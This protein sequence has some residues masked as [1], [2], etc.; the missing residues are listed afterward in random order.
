MVK[1]TE[2][3]VAQTSQGSSTGWGKAKQIAVPS[4]AKL[5]FDEDSDAILCFIGIKDISDKVLDSKGQP[6]A[7]GEVVYYTF[8][9]G[10][11]LVSMPN[12]YALSQAIFTPEKFYYL[13]CV[14][15]V[16]N[17]NPSFNDMK[18]FAIY[19]LGSENETVPCDA[20]RTGASE[21]KLT[22]PAIAELNYT[23]LNYPLRPEPKKTI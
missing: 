15:K 19:E 23:K 12:S 2:R 16:P 14:S 3:T 11:K 5:I 21:I 18:N 20:S 17:K 4:G 8:T 1:R 7:A 22:L 10:K 13:H 9:D 6:Q